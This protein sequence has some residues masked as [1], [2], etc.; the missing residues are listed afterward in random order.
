MGR[1]K[2]RSCRGLFKVRVVVVP[3]FCFQLN[4]VAGIFDFD[5]MIAHRGKRMVCGK[6]DLLLWNRPVDQLN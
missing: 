5:V 3:L 4:I 1:R 2:K 6:G